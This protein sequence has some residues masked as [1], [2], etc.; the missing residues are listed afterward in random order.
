MPPQTGESGSGNATNEG[1]KFPAVLVVESSRAKGYA[2]SSDYSAGL[3]FI[4]MRAMADSR[5]VVKSDLCHARL[6]Y[7]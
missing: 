6:A 3:R 7:K 5:A 2:A 1:E 4:Y